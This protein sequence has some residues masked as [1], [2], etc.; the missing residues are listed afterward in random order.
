MFPVCPLWNEIRVGDENPGRVAMCA[1]DPNRL[2]GLNEQ[3]LI[4][5]QRLERFQNLIE[6]L[7]GTCCAANASVYNKLVRVFCDVTIE[8]VL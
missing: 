6:V 2:A 3:G 4:L 8:I 1:E 5:L 7:P